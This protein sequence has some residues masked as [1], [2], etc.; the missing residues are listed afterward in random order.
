MHTENRIT[1]KTI[2]AK[3]NII[4]IRAMYQREEGL[5]KDLGFR[6]MCHFDYV[7]IVWRMRKLR[8]IVC[9]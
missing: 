8:F 7:K 3:G 2:Y 4:G 5:A 1:F 6:V 9:V